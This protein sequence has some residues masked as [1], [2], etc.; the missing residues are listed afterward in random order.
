MLDKK[1]A[2][3]PP[4]PTPSLSVSI[5]L[6]CRRGIV[7]LS[8]HPPSQRDSSKKQQQDHVRVKVCFPQKHLIPEAF[9]RPRKQIQKKDEMTFLGEPPVCSQLSI[10]PPTASCDPNRASYP[11]QSFR[12]PTPIPFRMQA[13]RCIQ[14]TIKSATT[15]TNGTSTTEKGGGNRSSFTALK[16]RSF[17]NRAREGRSPAISTRASKKDRP[18]PSSLQCTCIHAVTI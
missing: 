16:K 17:A 6:S 1:L 8:I 10:P 9:C 11:P 2:K 15:T 14:P 13:S 4:T 12:H 3:S 18:P 5:P 7:A